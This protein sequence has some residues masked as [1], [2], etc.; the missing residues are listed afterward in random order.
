MGINV[1][2]IMGPNLFFR[3][4]KRKKIML[5]KFTKGRSNWMTDYK[6]VYSYFP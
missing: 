3:V 1:D 4:S 6:D 5:L 2:I